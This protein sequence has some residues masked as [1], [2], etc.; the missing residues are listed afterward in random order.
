MGALVSVQPR[1]PLVPI[2][3]ESLVPVDNTNR[4]AAGCY[5]IGLELYKIQNKM[6]KK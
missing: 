5:A 6:I 1:K 4:V 3:L 2:R